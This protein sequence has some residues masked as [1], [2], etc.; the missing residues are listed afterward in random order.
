MC[1]LG[2]HGETAVSCRFKAMGRGAPEI[3]YT[4]IPAD[5]QTFRLHKLTFITEYRDK[6]TTCKRC[7]KTIKVEPDNLRGMIVWEEKVWLRDGKVFRGRPRF[8]EQLTVT[9][10]GS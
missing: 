4:G 7:G 2:L 5:A 3:D 9:L 6:I 8:T 10:D 1:Q